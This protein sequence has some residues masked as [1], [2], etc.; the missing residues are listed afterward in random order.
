MG[1]GPARELRTA[2]HDGR[3]RGGREGGRGGHH[4]HRDEAPPAEGLKLG[5]HYDLPE[6]ELLGLFEVST[7]DSWVARNWDSV[8]QWTADTALAVLP[9]DLK[10][11]HLKGLAHGISLPFNALSSTLLF[12]SWEQHPTA[13]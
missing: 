5:A 12:S 8:S 3:R 6:S 13:E 10:A 11:A 1:A 7:G 9:K 4:G 2:G